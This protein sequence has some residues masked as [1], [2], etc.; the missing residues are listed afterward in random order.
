LEV[1]GHRLGGVPENEAQETANE[2]LEHFDPWL[3]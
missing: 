1:E 3:G 2:A